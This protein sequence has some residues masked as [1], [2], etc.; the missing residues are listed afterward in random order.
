MSTTSIERE[1]FC[2]LA[3]AEIPVSVCSEEQGGAGCIGCRASSR[4]CVKCRVTAVIVDAKEGLCATCLERAKK[5]EPEVKPGLP[6]GSIVEALE[7]LTDELELIGTEG[8]VEALEAAN[9]NALAEDHDPE[10][11]FHRPKI[12]RQDQMLLAI[13]CEHIQMRDEKNTVAAP[14]A[15]LGARARLIPYEAEEVLRKLV[16]KGQIVQTDE[17]WSNI[18]ILVDDIPKLFEALRVS[19]GGKH[20]RKGGPK[21]RILSTGAKS[22]VEALLP[23]IGEIYGML[24]A[25]HMMLDNEK[26]VSGAVPLLQLSFKTGAAIVIQFLEKLRDEGMIAQRDG[27]RSIILLTDVTEDTRPALG[28]K[29]LS[30]L[31]AN[32]ARAKIRLRKGMG[33]AQVIGDV[34]DA[35][36]E[37]VTQLQDA[38]RTIGEKIISLQDVLVDLRLAKRLVEQADETAAQILPIATTLADNLEKSNIG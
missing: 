36:D 34:I 13:L 2:Q 15:I 8:D 5:K 20:G 11:V 29:E 6:G 4:R 33:T 12:M 27:W 30:R 24:F 35:I 10:S 26:V 1:V 25:R 37:S 18:E 16:A 28:D 21:L 38:H 9:A 22:D 14:I 17:A 31:R 7:D 23:T 32:V 3:D 19:S